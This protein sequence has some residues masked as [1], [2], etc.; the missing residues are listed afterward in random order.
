MCHEGCGSNI[1]LKRNIHNVRK[2]ANVYIRMHYL[3]FILFNYNL[4]QLCLS[5]LN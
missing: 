1:M 5:N 2:I 3:L 4:L